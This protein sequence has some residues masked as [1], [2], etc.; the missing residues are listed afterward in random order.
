MEDTSTT[1]KIEKMLE[2]LSDGRWHT[3]NE[4]QEKTK[5]KDVQLQQI[6]KFLKEYG[7]ILVDENGKRLKLEKQAKE[8]LHKIL[9]A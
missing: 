3:F 6:A 5:M 1:T 4:I 8:F 7:L 2:T 9:T